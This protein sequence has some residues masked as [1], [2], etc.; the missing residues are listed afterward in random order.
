[1]GRKRNLSQALKIETALR[2]R[3]KGKGRIYAALKEIFI[4]KQV[5]LL[6]V[7]LLL[8]R[9]VILF[10]ISPFAIAF[11]ATAWAI[12]Q[13]RMFAITM[14]VI[15]GALTYSVEQAVFISLSA[16]VFFLLT[17]F[18]KERKNIRL[19]MLFV[20]ISTAVARLFL[21]SLPS[22]ITVYEGLHLLIEGILG[23]VLLLIFMQSLP[24]LAL[25]RYQ[26]ALKSEELIC[27]VILLASVLTGLIGWQMYGVQLEH[28]FSRYI[29]L[30]LAFV[31]GAAVGSTVGVVTGL[32]LS[33]ANVA[34]LY[35]MS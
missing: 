1:M 6:L 21:Y 12:Y 4:E 2:K 23:I 27:I 24:L 28:V 10:N 9:A 32:I 22:Q 19:L 31:G 18:V 20:F 7:G 14:F 26:P 15:L 35:Q 17:Q 29:V 16:A 8:G 33:L 25:K 5:L 11:I 13:K 30:I 34:N 3:S